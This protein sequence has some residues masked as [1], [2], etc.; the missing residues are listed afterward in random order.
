[1]EKTEMWSVYDVVWSFVTKLCASV[2]AN[3]R[4]LQ[5]W[6]DARKA[7]GG[8]PSGGKTIQEIHEEVVSTLAEGEP[9]GDLEQAVLLVFQRIENALL[10]VPNIESRVNVLV[11]RADTIRAHLKDC[12][13]VLSQL[14]VVK[15][16]GQKS[17][18]VRVKNGVYPNPAKYWI[19]VLR[20]DNVAVQA[21]DGRLERFVHTTNPKTGAPINAIKCFE[22]I[23][24]ACIKFQLHVLGGCVQEEDL[25][26]L[27][28]Y[29]G[30]HGYGG[31]RSAGEGKYVFTLTKVKEATYEERQRRAAKTAATKKREAAKV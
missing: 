18:A 12:A 21:S 28:E 25:R 8:R 6:I 26:T 4:V 7:K 11:L 31:E 1:M 16:E 20:P 17:L 27:M 5:D 23:Q 2:P 9:E 22:W 15:M 3:P 24:P 13:R 14:Y 29:G 30:V 10:S 19:P